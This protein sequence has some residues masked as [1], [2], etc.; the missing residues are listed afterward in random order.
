MLR[1]EIQTENDSNEERV[2]RKTLIVMEAVIGLNEMWLK[3]HPSDVCLLTCGSISYDFARE[4]LLSR[5]IDLKTIP[6]L[7]G[8]KKGLCIDFICFDVAIRRMV[9]QKAEPGMIP[10]D[11]KG[12]LHVVTEVYNGSEVEV[13]DPTKEIVEFGAYRSAPAIC[14]C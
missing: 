11:K 6:I 7:K 13:I 2:I 3:Q 9:G 10:T 5:V 8:T 4:K 1:F 14:S 12:V